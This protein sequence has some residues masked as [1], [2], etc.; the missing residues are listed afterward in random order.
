MLHLRSFLPVIATAITLLAPALPTRAA[1]FVN[2]GELFIGFYA[3]GGQGSSES[4]LVNIG[5]AATFR[6]ATTSFTLSSVGSFATDLANTYGS[7]WNTR[8][9]LYWGVYGTNYDITGNG[10]PVN[11]DPQYT[12]YGTKSQ[13]VLG[14]V[15]T[16]FNRATTAT[17][18]IP[19]SFMYDVSNQTGV[20]GSNSKVL[21]QTESALNNDFKKFQT[22]AVAFNGYFQAS[23]GNFGDGT[24][25]TALDLF[26]MQVRTSPGQVG[27]YEGTFTISN[28][29]IVT[30]TAVPEPGTWA[31][32]AIAAGAFWFGVRRRRIKAANV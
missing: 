5:S 11:G 20:A 14:T 8:V 18:S 13:A 3:D 26:R 7:D 23:L 31:L 17:Q 29:G 1:A 27:T 4:L 6:D 21:I 15:T 12:L 10:T 16:P 2:D 24:A 9:D 22:G 30:F 28:T 25:G 19:S 32:L